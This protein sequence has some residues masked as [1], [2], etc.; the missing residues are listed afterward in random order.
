MKK[1]TQ[2]HST[3]VASFINIW[4]VVVPFTRYVHRGVVSFIKVNKLKNKIID[5]SQC[6]QKVNKSNT[7]KSKLWKLIQPGIVFEVS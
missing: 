1:V 4:T 6:K 7:T 5:C 3:C 2:S